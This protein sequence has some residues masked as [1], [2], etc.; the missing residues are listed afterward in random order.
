MLEYAFVTE[1]KKKIIKLQFVIV[2]MLLNI[3]NVF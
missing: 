3:K 2:S 1:I